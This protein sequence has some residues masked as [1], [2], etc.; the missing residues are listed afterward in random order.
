MGHFLFFIPSPTLI[1]G[2]SEPED[3]TDDEQTILKQLD[4]LLASLDE[5]LDD[6]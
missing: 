6:E 1:P 2:L 3:L 5:D 4:D